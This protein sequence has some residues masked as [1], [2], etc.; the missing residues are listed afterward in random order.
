M[1]GLRRA[2][3]SSQRQLGLEVEGLGS[4]FRLGNGRP[5]VV[6]VD[7]QGHA[8]EIVD[9][10]GGLIGEHRP[11]CIGAGSHH[12]EIHGFEAAVPG[13]PP[14]ENGGAQAL[15]A[16]LG[17]GQGLEGIGPIG[18]D[19]V[20]RR[21]E[22]RDGRH[23][24]HRG[25]QQPPAEPAR[26]LGAVGTHRMGHEQQQERPG[27]EH[28]VKDRRQVHDHQAHHQDRRAGEEHR[29]HAPLPADHP[30]SDPGQG[31]GEQGE[32]PGGV[33]ACLAHHVKPF[34]APGKLLAKHIGDA[35]EAF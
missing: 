16:D 31:Q 3:V 2:A 25:Q 9:L 21:P 13:R 32:H 33:A 28:Q 15:E 8:P 35:A 10:G 22:H 34:V 18:A 17:L 5:G 19:I 11:A 30:G 29:R 23:E 6:L 12:R 7:P 24:N 4:I 27:E 26:L 20:R 1:E 14:I